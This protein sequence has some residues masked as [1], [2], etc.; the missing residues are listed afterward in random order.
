MKMIHDARKKLKHHLDSATI[1]GNGECEQI[2]VNRYSNVI[3]RNNTKTAILKGT[4][5]NN[6]GTVFY[7][8]I[9]TMENSDETIFIQISI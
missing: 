6:I 4:G 1:D 5:N 2:I 9:K 8:L 7:L 3:S